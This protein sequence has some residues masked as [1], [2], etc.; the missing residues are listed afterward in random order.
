MGMESMN[1]VAIPV[2]VLVAPGPEV[3][4]TVPGIPEARREIERADHLRHADPGLAGGAR[5]AVSH[6]HRCLLV[7]YQNVFDLVL[8]EQRIIN[9]KGCTTRIAVYVLDPLILQGTNQH[10]GTRQ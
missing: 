9:M 10:I 3:T 6:V 4:S 1:A 5:I 8:P 2:M 7:P